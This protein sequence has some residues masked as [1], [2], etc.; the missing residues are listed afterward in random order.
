VDE[1]VNEK[2]TPSF[3]NILGLDF[4][5]I[6]GKLWEA[7]NIPILVMILNWLNQDLMRIESNS[8][9]MVSV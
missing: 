2:I 4:D 6:T 1:F 5:A 7:G 9:D 8:W 3:N